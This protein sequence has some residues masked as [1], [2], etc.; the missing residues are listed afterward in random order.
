M[1]RTA[2]LTGLV[3]AGLF[4]ALHLPFLPASL[5]D[6]DSVNFALGVRDYDVSRHQPH[7]PGYPLFMVAAKA[8]NR[9]GLSEVHA[10]ALLSVIGGAVGVFALMGLF[11]RLDRDRDTGTLTWL[12]TL[13]AAANPLYW[14]TSAR[15]LSDLSGLSVALAIQAGAL[16]VRTARSFVFVCAAAAVAAGIRSQVVWLTVPMLVLAAVRL[17]AGERTRGALLSGVAAYA[18]GALLWFVPLL[19]VSGGPAAYWSALEFQ[20]SADLTGVTMLATTPTLRQLVLS[21]RYALLA[22]WGDWR[23]G[24]IVMA[25]LLL[26]LIRLWRRSPSSLISLVAGFGPYF[27]FDVLFQET[28]TTRYAL[29]LVIPSAYLAVRGLSLLPDSAATLGVLALAGYSASI[30]DGVLPKYARPDAPVYRMLGDWTGAAAAGA[31]FRPPAVMM[32]RRLE[33]DTRRSLQ[34]RASE[35]PAFAARLVPTPKHEWLDV[36][37]YW[38]GGGRAPVWFVADP[39]R[40][41]LALIHGVRR[42]TLYRWGFEPTILLGGSRPSEMDWYVLESPDWYLGE[43]WALTP[44]TAGIAGEDQRGPGLAPIDGWI[45]RVSGPLS[46]MIGGRNLTSAGRPVQMHVEVDGATVADSSVAPGFFLRTLQ[47]ATLAGEGAYARIRVSSNST[48]LAIEQFDAQP[49]GVVMSG[50][51]EGWHEQE[52]DPATGALWRWTSD[53]AELKVRAQGRAV[54]LTLRGEIEAAATS[55]VTVRVGDRTIAEFDV[56]RSFTRT[57][58]VPAD[59]M[60]TAETSVTISTSASSVPAEL[61]SRSGDRRRLGLKLYEYRVSAAS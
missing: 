6:L 10:L 24:A 43:G 22:P 7:P 30:N 15:P 61:N 52:Y 47:V 54:S 37:K 1:T 49:A 27:V 17:P 3:L 53:R 33:L 19:L 39:L 46:I 13:L 35:L 14:L 12:A 59:A 26:G 23:L 11:T 50:A 44:E 55:H 56:E 32:H 9:L 48:D 40:S 20:G 60:V 36:V 4:L 34:W 21:M 25:L 5:E 38:N 42:P 18:V 28:V 51:G 8:L 58:I 2:R 16:S 29:P 45:R 57:V 41:D 31:G